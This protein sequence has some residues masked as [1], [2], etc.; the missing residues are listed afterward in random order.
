MFTAFLAQWTGRHEWHTGVAEA[1]GRPRHG[2][3]SRP[4]Q[5]C[6]AA[7]DDTTTAFIVYAHAVKTS[8]A[9]RGGAAQRSSLPLEATARFLEAPK[10]ERFV[11]PR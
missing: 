10:L 6:S 1:A 11:A 9:A 4:A 7:L 8:R 5:R 2:T 3:L